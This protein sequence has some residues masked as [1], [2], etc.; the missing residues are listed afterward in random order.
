[1]KIILPIIITGIALGLILKPTKKPEYLSINFEDNH[2]TAPEPIQ[3]T[4]PVYAEEIRLEY[5]ISDRA[6]DHVA[7][8][9][10]TSQKISEKFG[11]Y[12]QYAIELYSRESGLNQEAINPS[13]GACGLVQSLPCSKME[14]ELEDLD[15]QLEWGY[16]YIKNRYGN[17]KEAL[18]FHDE[19]N[20]Y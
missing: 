18:N 5:Q 3:I 19:H 11:K 16:K 15:C 9:F 4:K 20:W 14:C 13:S 12:G 1:M 2:Y 10:E 17:A 6:L 8:N 7:K